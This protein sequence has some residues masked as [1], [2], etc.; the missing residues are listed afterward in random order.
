MLARLSQPLALL[1]A[2]L[3]QL[4]VVVGEVGNREGAPCSTGPAEGPVRREAEVL[5]GEGEDHGSQEVEHLQTDQ[6]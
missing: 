5:K 2:A 4:K 3:L 1:A 6:E